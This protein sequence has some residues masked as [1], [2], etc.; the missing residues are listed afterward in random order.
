MEASRRL[1]PP[2]SAARAAC[3]RGRAAASIRSSAT[4]AAAGRRR[5]RQGVRAGGERILVFEVGVAVFFDDQRAA[6]ASRAAKPDRD[7]ARLRVDGETPVGAVRQRAHGLDAPGRQ[8][9]F[10]PIQQPPSRR[11]DARPEFWRVKR[12]NRHSRTRNHNA[13]SCNVTQVALDFGKMTWQGCRCVT[14]ARLFR[15]HRRRAVG[16]RV[17]LPPRLATRLLPRRQQPHERRHRARRRRPSP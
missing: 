11:K 9:P 16:R 6:P 8:P 10:E 12:E 17:A 3:Q 4:G 7:P 1:P 13:T 14:V 2:Y 5:Q 15:R